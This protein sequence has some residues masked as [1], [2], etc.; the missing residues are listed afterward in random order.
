MII[1][2]AVCCY[3]LWF[4]VYLHQLNPLIGPKISAKT[5]MWIHEKWGDAPN[6]NNH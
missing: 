1:L 4:I 2:T 5:I 3:M 6:I